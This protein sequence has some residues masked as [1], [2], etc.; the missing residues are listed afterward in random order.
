MA[1]RNLKNGSL[2]IKGGGSGE[3]LTIPIEE[4]N[5]SFTVRDEAGVVTN[6]G[7]LAGFSTPLEE[8]MEVSFGIKFEEWQGKSASGANPSPVD[9]LKK[10]GNAAA[11]TSTTSCG[12]F[13]VD[14]EFTISKPCSAGSEEDEVLTFPDFHADELTFEEGEEYNMI[15][16]RGRCLAVKPTSVRS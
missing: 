12:P 9:A 2:K 8:P 6:R 7:T 3:S 13:T 1:I 16:V 5:V 4:G 10:W 14:L 11:W 15:S